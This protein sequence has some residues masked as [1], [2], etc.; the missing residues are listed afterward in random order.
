MRNI[1]AMTKR[2]V[3]A[4]ATIVVGMLVLLPIG[5]TAGASGRATKAAANA[6]FIGKWVAT[7]TSWV[8]TSED[9]STGTCKGTTTSIGYKLSGCRVTGDSYK[10]T[11]SSG[12]TVVASESGTI[13]GSTANGISS[14]P[15]G[16]F[17]YTAHRFLICVVPKLKGLTLA[18]AKKALH[19]NRCSVGLVQ[20]AASRKVRAGRVFYSSPSAGTWKNDKAKVLLILSTG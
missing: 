16:S 10:F 9:L 14:G 17:H 6:N 13:S 20:R 15:T 4:V 3:F 2:T 11:I 7:T 18:A 1:E 12:G 5:N 19:K 8:V